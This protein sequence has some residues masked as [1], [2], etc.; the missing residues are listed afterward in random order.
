MNDRV[1][2]GTLELKGL[3]GEVILTRRTCE[4]V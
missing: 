4:R 3:D 2:I 1:R